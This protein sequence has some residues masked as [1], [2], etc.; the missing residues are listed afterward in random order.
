MSIKDYLFYKASQN[1]IPLSGTFELSPVCNFSCKMCYVR[2]SRKQIARE[3]KKEH[4][5]QEWVELA[6][7]CKEAGM[8][9]LL[10]TG[11]EPFIYPEFRS[12]YEQIHEMGIVISI[13]SNGTMIDAETVEWLKDHAPAR[14]NITMYGASSET[15]GRICNHPEGYERVVNAIR[16]LKE[17]GISVVINASIIPENAEDLQKIIEFGKENDIVVR[18]ATYMFPPIRRDI[19]KTD[20]R[21]SPQE[22]GRLNV[23]KQYYAMSKEQFIEQGRSCLAS[24]KHIS[25]KNEESWGNIGMNKCSAVQGAALFGLIGKAK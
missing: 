24:A 22:S 17:A 10:L 25:E 7:R 19:E 2:K 23:M 8:L 12:L 6:K 18:A 13:N 11:G 20:S 16:M 1:K 21:L 4:T 15:Y 9:Y 5:V 3:G 14:I